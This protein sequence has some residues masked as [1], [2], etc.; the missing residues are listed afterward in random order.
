MSCMCIFPGAACCEP[1]RPAS[2]QHCK[3][4]DASV[5]MELYWK[6][7]SGLIQSET[8]RRWSACNCGPS[9]SHILIPCSHTITAKQ[10]LRYSKEVCFRHRSGPGCK[11]PG[12]GGCKG[13]SIARWFTS[14]HGQLAI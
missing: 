9:P 8:E 10:D 3:I 13:T 14:L 12:P 2:E 5:L 6:S 4:C 11:L 7:S 1:W